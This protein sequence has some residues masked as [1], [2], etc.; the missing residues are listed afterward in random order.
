MILCKSRHAITSQS[1]NSALSKASGLEFP[2]L[3]AFS[4]RPSAAWTTENILIL[5]APGGN[6]PVCWCHLPHGEEEQASQLC[7]SRFCTEQ[8]SRWEQQVQEQSSA[9]GIQR[10]R[11][12]MAATEASLSLKQNFNPLRQDWPSWLSCQPLQSV[13]SSNRKK[14]SDFVETCSS[15]LP[16]FNSRSGFGMG[17]FARDSRGPSSG[18]LLILD[19]TLRS[20]GEEEYHDFSQ[21]YPVLGIVHFCT[22][23]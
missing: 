15:D 19:G 8:L 1:A 13:V 16:S 3:N 21:R 12:A 6:T 11:N 17:F 2:K 18:S 22:P 14:P 7:I 4:I 23:W 10:P 9:G 20:K 5:K